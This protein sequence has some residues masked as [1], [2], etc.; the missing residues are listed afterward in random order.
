MAR[1]LAQSNVHAHSNMMV[2]E[3]C[4]GLLVGAMLERMGGKGLALMGTGVIFVRSPPPPPLPP[5]PVFFFSTAL[6]IERVIF[7]HSFCLSPPSLPYFPS[8]FLSSW[9]TFI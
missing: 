3:M 4:Q 1:I 7:V 6:E 9:L 2:M 8:F 5:P